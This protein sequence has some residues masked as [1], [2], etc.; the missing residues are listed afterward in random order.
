MN[1]KLLKD[2]NFAELVNGSNA[3]TEAGKE[4]LNGYR[5]Y[6][7]SNPLTCGVVNNFVNEAK[8]FSFDAGLNS[9]LE[10]VEKFIKQHNISWQLASTCEA[11][12]NNN[13][14]YS[15]IAKL[16]VNKLEKILELDEA[17]VVSYIKAGALKDLQYIPEVRRVCKQVYNTNV[18]ESRT[19]Q[20]NITNPI[21]FVMVDE[22]QSFTF[23]VFNKTYKMN[24]GKVDEVVCDDKQF[25]RI[26]QLLESFSNN[27]GTIS[28]RINSARGEYSQFDLDSENGTLKFTKG[29]ICETFTNPSVFA[30][31]MNQ[32]SKVVPMNE[33]MSFLQGTSA[34]NEVFNALSNIAVLDN[35]NIV[36]SVNG[37]V[38]AIIEAENNVN[39]T[40][41]RSLHYGTSSK[42][43]DFMNEAVKDVNKMTGVNLNKMYESR[44]DEDLKK[45]QPE[46][47][48]K[49]Q[50]ELKANKNAQIEETKQKIAELSEKYK[51]DPAKL[52]LLN[53]TAEDL[54]LLE[55]EINSTKDLV[56]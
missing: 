44:I 20:Y 53:K 19:M 52:A 35:V 45:Q 33:R 24:E 21:S 9:I 26:N 38:C 41:F 4:M 29:N 56:G 10:S 13:S 14:S 16:G 25:N 49:I 7:Y 11:I 39:V 36:E 27:E 1:L 51:S 37:T 47:Y 23:N 3:V 32:L 46:E 43:Y 18:M 42:N 30:E 55:D 17:N 8:K 54:K 2:L 12:Q 50:E 15:Y 48:R 34:I 40:V 5:G 6:V 28:T 31:R 22:S